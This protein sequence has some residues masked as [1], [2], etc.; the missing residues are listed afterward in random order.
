MRLN[1]KLNTAVSLVEVFTNSVALFLLYKFVLSHLGVKHLGVWSVVLATTSLARFGDIG[2]A[3]GLS[4]FIAASMATNDFKTTRDYIETAF[5]ANL[6]LYSCAGLLFYV[7][8]SMGVKFVVSKDMLGE[9]QTLLSYAIA[10]F[11][12]LNLNAVIFSSLVGLQRMYLK[13]VISILSTVVQVSVAIILIPKMGLLGLAIGQICQYLFALI[14]GWFTVGLFVKTGK[15][16]IAPMRFKLDTFKAL[17]GFGVKL[18]AATLI[19]FLFEPATKFAL[20]AVCGLEALGYFEMAYKFV[21]Q[22]RNVIVA[23][24]QSL[25]PAYTHFD[26]LQNNEINSLYKKATA[27]TIIVGGVVFCTASILSPIMSILWIGHLN[28]YFVSFVCILCVGWY[29]NAVGNPAY[30]LGVSKGRISR[31]LIGHV[32]TSAGS[33]ALGFVLGHAIGP[34]GFVIA[35]SIALAAGATFSMINN[36]RM[37]NLHAL[38]SSSDIADQISSILAP[39]TKQF[40]VAIQRRPN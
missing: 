16:W 15:L 19:S 23:P 32:I 4:R 38:P 31:N 36:C 30:L 1:L 22:V 21:L 5:I 35:I 10:S 11:L 40:A 24:T 14:A 6:V 27:L 37:F 18:Q 3:A 13:S 12:C 8:L 17:F 39:L 33:P 25:V 20:S 26:V 28:T 7:P 34:I 2:A 9:A 29:V